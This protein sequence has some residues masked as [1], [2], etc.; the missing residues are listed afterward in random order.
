MRVTGYKI[1]ADG[2]GSGGE[3]ESTRFI[4]LSDPR[5]GTPVAM[6]D[7]HWS[8]ALRTTASACVGAK[9]LARRDSSVVGVIGVGNMGRTFLL[10]ARELFP[11]KEVWATSRRPESR[12]AFAQ[13][14]SEELGVPVVAK[15]SYE[16]VCRG[17]D[18]I[19]TG[20]P[21]VT[22]F[23]RSEWL[24]PGVFVAALGPDEVETE[25]YAT[26]DKIVVDYDR[27]HEKHPRS[28]Q[29]LTDLRPRGPDPVHAAL[30]E[31]VTG[32]KP[33]RERADERIILYTVG[34]TAHDVAIAHALYQRA[35][36][37]GAGIRIP[38]D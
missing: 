34:L 14:M 36:K 3:P 23:V 8:F 4:V 12:L 30:W 6:I 21:S 15:D 25:A 18:I 5:T 11:I 35:V 7:E 17:A 10:G 33:G 31:V 24:A 29:R 32:R 13:R 9:Y 16:E 27:E 19:V 1:A 38:L 26:S 37:E 28:L 2:T 20:T 22:P